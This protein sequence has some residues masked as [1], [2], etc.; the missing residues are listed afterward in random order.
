[1]PPSLCLTSKRP[2]GTG[3][4]WRTRS[5]MVAISPRFNHHL[6]ELWPDPEAFDPG[7]FSAERQEDKVH[8]YAWAPF[9]G[10]V[11]KCIGLHFA[12]A[13]VKIVLHHLLRNFEWH[14]DPGY[15]APMDLKVL[16]FPKDG[17]PVRLRR[18]RQDG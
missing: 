17:Q 14:V 10:G 4:A 18:R 12:G 8:R 11:H 15:R 7:R 1:M 5:R 6:A 9:G 13:E 3:R 16:P 2:A